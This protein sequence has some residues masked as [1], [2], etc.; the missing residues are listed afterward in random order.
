MIF[1]SL[2]NF[3]PPLYVIRAMSDTAVAFHAVTAAVHVHSDVSMYLPHGGL[4]AAEAVGINCLLALSG[5]LD[6]CRIITQNLMV[7]IHHTSPPLLNKVNSHIVMGQV[8]FHTLL[9][10]M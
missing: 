5:Q 10:S 8:A 1:C 2:L 7:G 6:V 3:Y 4:M 9:I